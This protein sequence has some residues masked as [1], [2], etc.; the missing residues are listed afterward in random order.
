MYLREA[1]PLVTALR[2]LL[3][4]SHELINPRV[5]LPRRDRVT[6]YLTNHGPVWTP[7]PAPVL[8]VDYLLQQGGYDDLVAITLFH[9]LVEFI[10]GLSPL[11]TRY[12]GHSTPALRSVEGITEIMRARKVHIFGT[13]PEGRSCIYS[14]DAP[15]G[16]FTK[17]GLMVAALQADA[18][19]VLAAQKGV[20]SFG[21]HLRLPAGA[22]LPLPGRP[23]GL[24]LPVWVPGRRAHITVAYRR[25][26][27]R[28]SAQER[29]ALPLHAQRAQ[30]DEEIAAIHRELSDLYRSLP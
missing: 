22:T 29:A 16:P 5:A 11:L 23:R 27:P 1:A 9:K 25:Y 19:I 14:F 6:V 8:T 7:F 12:F 20:E 10:P 24:Q 13:A 26:A 18:D 3:V 21:A 15:V 30:L 4:E 28:C 17:V 2:R